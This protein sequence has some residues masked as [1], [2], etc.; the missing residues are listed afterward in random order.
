M[1]TLRKHH[2]NFPVETKESVCQAYKDNVPRTSKWIIKSALKTTNGSRQNDN[3]P[4]H[5]QNTKRRMQKLFHLV[6]ITV[7]DFTKDRLDMEHNSTNNDGLLYWFFKTIN[8]IYRCKNAWLIRCRDITGIVHANMIRLVNM[9]FPGQDPLTLWPRVKLSFVH[10]HL[11]WYIPFNLEIHTSIIPVALSLGQWCV[12][13][14]VI[15]CGCWTVSCC[16]RT[17][18]KFVVSPFGLTT[19]GWARTR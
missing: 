6:K 1:W 13:E 11:F 14:N 19:S 4:V 12:L 9:Y 7:V 16:S 3:H 5:N 18:F 8:H 15:R 10:C 17:D 2:D